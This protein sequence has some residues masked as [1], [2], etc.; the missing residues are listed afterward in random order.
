MTQIKLYC[1]GGCCGDAV[2]QEDG[3]RVEIRA[4]MDDPGD[5]LYRATLRGEHGELSLGVMEPQ[6]G[7][8]I[9]RRRPDACDVAR[10]G[11]LHCIRVSCAFSFRRKLLWTPTNQPST[12]LQDDFFCS[13][14]ISVPRAHW[15]KN[16]GRLSLAFP[17]RCD[18]AFP[19]EA[20]FCFAR[21]ERVNDELCI[22]Y[23]FD[24]NEQ[25]IHVVLE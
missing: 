5:G 21:I 13:R 11:K 25:P 23:T 15:R 3:R 19:L 14:L 8:L 2:L 7:K 10:L 22:V 1:R 6:D 16:R 4:S 17:L 12:L 9:L 20:I 18:T 24:E